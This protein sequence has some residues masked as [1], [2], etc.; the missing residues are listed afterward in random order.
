MHTPNVITNI[1]ANLAYV[2]CSIPIKHPTVYTAAGIN[3]FNIC[4]NATERYT[5]A[6]FDNHKLN[7]N[8]AP[9]G[10]IF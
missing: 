3:A 9:T 1:F 2:N 8:N 4:I 10:T 6:V 5:Y 7:A